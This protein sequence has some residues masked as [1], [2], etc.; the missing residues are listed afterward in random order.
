CFTFLLSPVNEGLHPRHEAR[1]AV[2]ELPSDVQAE[3]LEVRLY[4]A[5]EF[6]SAGGRLADLSVEIDP[7]YPTTR[8]DRLLGI[9]D[10][11]RLFPLSGDNFIR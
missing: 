11:I 2:P 6:R 4:T 9:S 3:S 1:R 7:S 10:R 5:E 8:R